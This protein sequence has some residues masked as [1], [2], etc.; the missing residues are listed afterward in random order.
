MCGE[1]AVPEHHLNRG[2]DGAMPARA[3]GGIRV[4]LSARGCVRQYHNALLSPCRPIAGHANFCPGELSTKYRDLPS[5]L[6]TDWMVRGGYIERTFKMVVTP[7]VVQENSVFSR[8]SFAMMEDTGWYRA[9]Y[10]QAAPLDWGLGRGCQFATTSCKQWLN[11]NTLR[12][13]VVSRGLRPCRA[14]GLEPKAWLPVRDR[15][16]QTVA[17]QEHA[18]TTVPTCRSSRGDTRTR[19]C[20]A[21]PAITTRTHPVGNYTYTCFHAGQVLQVRIVKKGWLHKGGVVCPP[22]REMCKEEFD[23][24]KEYCKPGEEPLPPNLYPNDYLKCGARATA[25]AAILCTAAIWWLATV[26]Q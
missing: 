9:D 19:W 25:P 16:V 21:A 10:G 24:R 20:E 15:G 26:L 7:R 8:V 12:T 14:L 17:Q 18:Q 11:R 1:V 2:G 23:A 4:A 5:V 22:C 6:S 3:D 13:W